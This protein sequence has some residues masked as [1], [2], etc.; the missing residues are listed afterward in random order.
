VRR[1]TKEKRERERVLT[2]LDKNIELKRIYEEFRE[3][4]VFV[5]PTFEKHTRGRPNNFIKT[6][7]RARRRSR[8]KKR[9]REIF[10]S[11]DLGI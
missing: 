1:Q 8:K 11:F 5:A 10:F 4:R 3:F 7:K 6:H 2:F 9:E